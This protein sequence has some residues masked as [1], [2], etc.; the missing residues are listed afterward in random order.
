MRRNYIGSGS[1][2]AASLISPKDSAVGKGK[3]SRFSRFDGPTAAMTAADR[4]AKIKHVIA[5][6][7]AKGASAAGIYA[8]GEAVKCIG[9]SRGLFRY[10]RETLCEFSV[11]ILKDGATGWSQG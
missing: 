11:T 3:L 1:R 4:A 6:A 8:T 9:N 5:L 10:Y 2:P 7:E